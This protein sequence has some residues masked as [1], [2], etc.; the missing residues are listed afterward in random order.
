MVKVRYSEVS[1]RQGRES[2]WVKV[3]VRKEY[4]PNLHS[5]LVLVGL[6]LPGL[7]CVR[8]GRRWLCCPHPLG[9]EGKCPGVKCSASAIMY[10]AYM[11]VHNLNFPSAEWK[12]KSAQGNFSDSMMELDANVGKVVQAVRDAGIEWDT[13]VVFSSDNGLWIDA[14]PDAGYGR[15]GAQTE[16]R[17]RTVG[18]CPAFCGHPAASRQGPFYTV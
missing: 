4:L 7:T 11:K 9:G 5:R 16:H 13:I 10:V 15:S 12:G 6:G 18:A 2:D 8:S 17:S 3:P 14:W 1:S